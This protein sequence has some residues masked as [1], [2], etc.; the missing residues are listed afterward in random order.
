M[1]INLILGISLTENT[2]FEPCFSVFLRRIQYSID[3][4]LLEYCSHSPVSKEQLAVWINWIH[5]SQ[6]L[7]YCQNLGFSCLIPYKKCLWHL[8]ERCAYVL[9]VIKCETETRTSSLSVYC[10]S[11]TILAVNFG[12]IRTLHLH[13][14]EEFAVA[15]LI[16]D[17]FASKAADMYR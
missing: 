13:Y 15:S 4:S 6:L 17:I 16:F 12:L 1:R 14:V 3:H 9:N 8:P 11:V 2:L 5:S 10:S 7:F